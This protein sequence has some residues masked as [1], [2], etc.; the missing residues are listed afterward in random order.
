LSSTSTTP[1]STVLAVVMMTSRY[2]IAI[3]AVAFWCVIAI[4][5]PLAFLLVFI[6]PMWAEACWWNSALL[7][8]DPIPWSILLGSGTLSSLLRIGRLSAMLGPVV[9][10]GAGLASF[11]S[12]RDGT[13]S[14]SLVGVSAADV[15]PGSA[16]VV[17]CVGVGAALGAG[18]DFGFGVGFGF[19]FGIG[20][21]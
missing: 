5:A 16:N 10:A 18:A 2:S 7:I 1:L 12:F 9:Q 11:I 19:G 14:H 4:I 15:A 6:I 17:H 21:D 3:C 13:V 20:T 8:A